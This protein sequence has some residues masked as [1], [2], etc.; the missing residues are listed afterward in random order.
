MDYIILKGLMENETG[1]PYRLVEQ[2]A[3]KTPR[4]NQTYGSEREG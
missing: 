4:F 3:F 2:M 1:C